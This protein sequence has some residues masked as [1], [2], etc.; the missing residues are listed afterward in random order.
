VSY[1]R[2]LK[3]HEMALFAGLRAACLYGRA[4][5]R[6]HQRRYQEAVRLLEKVCQ[7]DPYHERNDLYHA[8]LGRSYLALD[9]HDDALKHLSRSYDPFCERSHLLREDGEKREF[10][11]FLIAFSNALGKVGQRERAQEVKHKA[12]K[13]LG[14]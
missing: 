8:Y 12:E 1:F 9:Q 2:V 11:E 10:V 14:P 5:T 4:L 7:L 6:F 3:G 13:F